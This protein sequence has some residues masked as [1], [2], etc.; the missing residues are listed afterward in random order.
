MTN[1][2]GCAKE[3][4]EGK[5]KNTYTHSAFA[6]RI[7]RCVNNGRAERNFRFSFSLSAWII[8]LWRKKEASAR[9][10][11]PH[12]RETFL[13]QASSSPRAL[14]MTPRDLHENESYLFRSN[15]IPSDISHNRVRIQIYIFTQ[16][17]RFFCGWNR[18]DVN[19]LSNVAECNVELEIII[20][21]VFIFHTQISLRLTICP[22]MCFRHTSKIERER[23]THREEEKKF[24]MSSKRTGVIPTRW[25]QPRSIVF[26]GANRGSRKIVVH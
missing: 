25:Y 15:C 8:G 7:I 3:E 17:H 18:E 19:F 20:F 13:A 1:T 21:L 11:I 14:H 5:K 16:I 22:R 24:I 26:K 10:G 9:R 4:E 23:E 12:R 2:R 6:N